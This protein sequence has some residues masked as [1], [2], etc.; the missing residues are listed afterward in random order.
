MSFING[1]IIVMVYMLFFI[2]VGTYLW[3]MG[4]NDG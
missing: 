3:S 1:P 4:D 2:A